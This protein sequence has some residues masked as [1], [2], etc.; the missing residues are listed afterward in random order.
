[1]VSRSVKATREALLGSGARPRAVSFGSRLNSR[2]ALS[3]CP[4]VNDYG[5]T[6]DKDSRM[7][8]DTTLMKLLAGLSD[9]RGARGKRHPLPALLALAVVAMLAGRTSY[10]AFVQY[11]KER[12]WPFRD[13][14]IP[15]F[16]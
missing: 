14:L 1:M 11:G 9:P 16:V 5:G 6:S 7:D 10:E 4:V 8:A 3:P 15:H 2:H 13:C 12:G